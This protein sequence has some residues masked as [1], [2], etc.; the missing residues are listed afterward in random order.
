M[1]IVALALLAGTTLTAIGCADMNFSYAR[2]YGYGPGF[3]NCWSCGPYYDGRYYD[4]DRRSDGR[5]GL[6]LKQITRSIR[7]AKRRIFRGL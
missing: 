3:G 5:H 4:R 1:R 2:P 6:Q 7:D